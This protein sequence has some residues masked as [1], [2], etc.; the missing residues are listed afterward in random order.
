MKSKNIFRIVCA[1]VVSI[2]AQ[3]SCTEKIDLK[4]K[5]SSP[6]L[7]IE[8]SVNDNAGPYFVYISKSKLYYQD[9]TFIGVSSA[10][11]IISDDAGNRDTLTE[12][13]AGI[14]QSH[15][16]QGTVGRTYKLEVTTEGTTY[17]SLCKMPAP[18]D[19]DSIE[20]T[21]ETDTRGNTKNR[22]DILV[23][24]P[25][26]VQN[27]YRVISYLNDTISGGFHIHSDRLWDGK[28]RSF[29][30]PQSGFKTGD[31]LRVDLQSIDAPIYTYFSEF[32][33]NQNNFGAPA[34]PAN[35]DPVYTPAALG[36]FNAYSVK[37]KT[38][39]AP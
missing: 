29:G 3:T 1:V 30:V 9:N 6:Q 2:I 15:T 32:N 21:T 4:L 37:T 17:I 10:V 16:L 13:I 27:Q 11:V 8:G 14:Y 35:P 5:N 23:R 34:A 12:T 36:Y 22:A 24:D 31:S 20:I 28:L 33:Q 38:V 19:I 39:V 7:V 18:V 26:G 25:A